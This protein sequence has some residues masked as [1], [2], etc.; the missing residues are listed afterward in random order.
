MPKFADSAFSLL[1]AALLLALGCGSP[2]PE[3]T[4][5]PPA[6]QFEEAAERTGLDF[7]H[8]LGATGDYFVPEIMGAGVALFDYDGDGDLDVYLPQGSLLDS[9]KSFSD[10][11]FPPPGPGLAGGQLYRNEIIPSGELRFVNVTEES[12]IQATGYGM[13]V[14]VGD[15]DNDG[16]PDLYLTN[17]GPNQLYHNNGDG[18]FADVTTLGLDDERWSA[19]AAF[20]DYDRDGDLDLVVVNYIDFHITGNKQCYGRTG[21][22]DYCTPKAYNSVPDRLLRNDDGKFVDVTEA[23]GLTAAHGNGLGV[24]CADFD[25]DGWLDIYVANDAVAN[26]L[27]R[28]NGRGGFEDVALPAGVAFNADG[29]AEAGMG[30]AAGDFDLDGDEDLFLTHLSQETNT[31]YVNGGRGLFRDETN[32]YGLGSPSTPFTGFGVQWLDYNHDGLPDLFIANG[33]VT[34]MESQRGSEHPFRQK[35]HLYRGLPGR[36]ERV[37]AEAGPAFEIEEVSRG[38]AFGDIDNDGDIDIVVSNNNGPARLLLNQQNGLRWIQVRLTGVDDARDAYGA[39]VALLTE[40]RSPVWR[41]VHADGSYLSSSSP[42][43]HFG[44]GDAAR[45]TGVG[46]E[47]LNGRREIFDAEPGSVNRVQQGEGRNWSETEGGGN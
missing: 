14:A 30:I 17:F 13:G 11:I 42:I 25:G 45:L 37:A 36:F 20:C 38:A 6:A 22:R 18:T 4:S 12:G 24:V 41:R 3:Q 1:P 19:S 26:Q 5:A 29:L 32:R 40:G 47:W 34:T 46:V 2:P 39:R 7:R 9:S 27:W 8:F 10:S 21:A 28:N 35:N 43:V 15:F 31:L 44:L 23:A 33:G 16:F